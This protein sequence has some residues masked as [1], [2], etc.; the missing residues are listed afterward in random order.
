MCIAVS[1]IDAVHEKLTE[2]IQTKM[3]DSSEKADKLR[4]QLSELSTMCKKFDYDAYT[5]KVQTN[6]QLEALQCEVDEKFM[7]KVPDII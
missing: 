5:L 1:D 2:D 7:I 6:M 4:Q 3:E